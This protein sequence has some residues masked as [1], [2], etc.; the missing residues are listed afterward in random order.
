MSQSKTL[1]DALKQA[2]RSSGLKYKDVAEHLNISEV[3]VRRIFSN[4][5][6]SL[7]RLE[8]ICA[9]MGMEISD[10]VHFMEANNKQIS[11]LTIEQEKEFATDPMMLLMCNLVMN[12]WKFEDIKWGYDLDEPTLIRYLMKLSKVGIIELLPL[13]KIKLLV[14]PSFAWRTD[15]P[16]L[17]M[18][19]Q[20]LVHEFFNT[21]F[22][23][24]DRSLNVAVSMV[25]RK[26]V[27]Q[28]AEKLKDLEAQFIQQCRQDRT[29]PVK[30]RMFVGLVMGIRPWQLKIYDQVRKEPL[31]TPNSK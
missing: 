1:I 2:L 20:A 13:N 28:F 17:T 19:R 14:S 18:F 7:L 9:M 8:E 3:S 4:E 27:T 30:D 11:Q 5:N 21:S 6:F 15:G 22:D 29:L 24:E 10:L 23:A 16:V 31:D 26:T 25:S 12:G